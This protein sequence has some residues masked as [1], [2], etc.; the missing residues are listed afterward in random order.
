M[1]RKPWQLGKTTTFTPLR[2][3]PYPNQR[4]EEHFKSESMGAP[5][6]PVCYMLSLR[7]QWNLASLKGLPQNS[8]WQTDS[9]FGSLW[10]EMAHPT[11]LIRF[12]TN[13]SALITGK[14]RK[15][16][17]QLFLTFDYES[18]YIYWHIFDKC[19]DIN[20]TQF[21]WQLVNRRPWI[22]DHLFSQYLLILRSNISLARELWQ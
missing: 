14:S 21:E 7:F 6:W 8:R 11:G 2:R 3:N 16:S 9:Q 1:E 17:G 5:G 13:K 18:L 12:F 20:F 19:K 22:W 10:W 15:L 4:I